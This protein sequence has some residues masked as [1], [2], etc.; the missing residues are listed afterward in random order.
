[1]KKTLTDRWCHNATKLIKFDPDRYAVHDEL[2]QHL[3]DKQEELRAQGVPEEEIETQAVEAMG[4]AEEIAPQL[5]AIHKPFW[6]YTYRVCCIILWILL[7]V[8]LPVLLFRVEQVFSYLEKPTFYDPVQNANIHWNITPETTVSA[9]EYTFTLEQVRLSGETYKNSDEEIQYLSALIK[10]QHPQMYNG[11]ELM[12]FVWAEDSLGNVY[13]N[14]AARCYIPAIKSERFIQV[15]YQRY[16]FWSYFTLRLQ[17]FRS[18]GIKWIDLHYDR[19]DTVFTIRI[20][21]PGG[22][23]R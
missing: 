16:L 12:D 7:V 11:A 20:D 23:D 17:G 21:L 8:M 22:E 10:V 1:M 9:G 4:S 15:G 18:D 14:V 6:G 19:D 3:L 2:K 5:A 13:H